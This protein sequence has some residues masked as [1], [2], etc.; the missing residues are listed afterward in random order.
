VAS[1]NTYCCCQ[2]L[3]IALILNKL[4]GCTSDIINILNTISNLFKFKVDVSASTHSQF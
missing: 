4:L 1:L 2:M 3:H